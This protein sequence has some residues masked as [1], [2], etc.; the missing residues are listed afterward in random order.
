MTHFVVTLIGCASIVAMAFF[1][2]WESQGDPSVA[3]SVG[4]VKFRAEAF[5]CLLGLGLFVLVWAILDLLFEERTRCTP[6]PTASAA[7]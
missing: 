4:S 2:R 3:D 7:V 6:A 1:I 5:S